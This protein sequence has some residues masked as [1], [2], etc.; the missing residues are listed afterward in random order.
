LNRGQQ[1]LNDGHKPG[2]KRYLITGQYEDSKLA[3]RQILLIPEISIGSYQDIKVFFGSAQQF[4]VLN[5]CPS[6]LLNS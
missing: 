2:D 6:H 3:P 1:S 4:A 5:S